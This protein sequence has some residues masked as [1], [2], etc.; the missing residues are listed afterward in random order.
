[1]TRDAAHEQVDLLPD[2]VL[3]YR[4]TPVFT[5]GTFPAGLLH[6][7]RTAPGVWALIHV[8]EGQL[9][10][11][12]SD[13]KSERMLVPGDPPGVAAPGQIHEVAALGTVRFYI[14]FCRKVTPSHTRETSGSLGEAS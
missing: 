12:I 9:R 11:R 13:P 1:M 8:L 5:E 7:H 10:F 2:G 14:E 6:E 3:P 4:A